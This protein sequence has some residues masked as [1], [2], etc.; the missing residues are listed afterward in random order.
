[1]NND[2]EKAMSEFIIPKEKAVCFSGHRPEK[3]PDG[4]DISSPV[5]GVIKSLLHQ[6]IAA[7]IDDGYTC[8]ITGL[9][10]GIDLIAGEL[11]LEFKRN[12]P[13]IELVAAVPYRAQPKNFH[14]YEKFVYGCILNEAADIIYVSEEYSKGCMQK[15]NRFMIDNSS[16]LIAAVDSYK[17]GTGQTIRL[18]EK[19]GI[20][21]RVINV[22]QISAAAAEARSLPVRL[23]L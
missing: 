16:R 21:V 23:T 11:T 17:S 10:R 13:R 19:A 3:L 18:A 1:M 22:A 2:M 20:E 14:S 6:E 7:A 12:D 9:A 4:G 15:R 8:F 5:M